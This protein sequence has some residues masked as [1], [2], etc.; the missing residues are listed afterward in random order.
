[1][2]AELAVVPSQALALGD[3]FDRP[4]YL[5]IPVVPAEIS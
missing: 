4:T 3:R 2:A 1:M 5:E